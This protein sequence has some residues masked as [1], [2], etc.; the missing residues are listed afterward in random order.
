MTEK[1]KILSGLKNNEFYL[2]G[3]KAIDKKTLEPFDKGNK[4]FYKNGRNAINEDINE[5]KEIKKKI[6][7][8]PIKRM[9]ST[10]ETYNIDDLPFLNEEYE[11]INK[12]L[13]NKDDEELEEIQGKIY[14]L[15]EGLEH[16][17][18]IS[19][20]GII[21]EGKKLTKEQKQK[22][23]EY[24]KRLNEGKPILKGKPYYWIGDIPKGYREAT[25]QEAIEKNN[26]S[27]YGKYAIDKVVYDMYKKYKI[28]LGIDYS[29]IELRQKLNGIRKKIIKA[30]QLLEIDK[31]HLGIDK[32]ESKGI[33]NKVK[34]G[35]LKVKEL[36]KIY[37]WFSKLLHKR[38][39]T[40][41]EEPKFELPKNEEIKINKPSEHLLKLLN[42]EIKP[43]I[44]FRTGKPITKEESNYLLR[45]ES[46]TK[47]FKR[48]KDIIELDNKYFNNNILI[49]KYAKKLFDKEFILLDSK[50]YDDETYKKLINDMSYHSV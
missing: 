38:L 18:R 7:E 11:R 41:Y 14:D 31:G 12:E 46:N 43:R 3:F 50:Y 44:D 45:K 17:K 47:T 39:K 40:K 4:R 8:E 10:D 9:F 36:I 34:D 42:T 23:K 26:V 15:I 16:L 24:I 49:P 32:Y 19:G 33:Q 37:K 1:D 27:E 21:Y 20:K 6:K 13:E 48:G 29:N 25:Q 30:M 22:E 2:Y 35:E 28:M 5:I